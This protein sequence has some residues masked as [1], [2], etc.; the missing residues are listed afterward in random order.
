MTTLL[1]VFG[2]SFGLSI[3]LTPVARS[4]AIRC[5]LIDEPDGRRKIHPRGIP[6]A[7]GPVLL[8]SGGGAILIAL[9]VHNPLQSWLADQ[10]QNLLSLFLAAFV[11]CLLGIIDD[12]GHLRGR[13]KLVGQLLAITIVM[14]TGL[15]V[16]QI[17]LFDWDVELGLLAVP[18]TLFL[19]LGAI[20]SLNLIDG[21]DGLL[22]CV[23]LIISLAMAVMAI[24]GGLWATACVAVALAGALLGFLRFNFPPASIFLGDS[25]SMLIGLAIGSLAIR[26]SLKGPATIA[27]AAP[28]A[29]LAIPIFDTTAAIIRR[30]LTGRS[31]YTTDRGH[32]HHCLLRRGLSTGGV[33]LWISF[34][35]LLTVCGALVS[36]ALHNELLA[37]VTASVVVSILI[38]TRIF[39]YAEFL[40][41]KERLSSLATSFLRRRARGN[42]HEIQVRLQGTADWNELW[43]ALTTYASQLNLSLV[44]LNVNAPLLHEGYH[45]C[46]DRFEDEADDGN[47]WCAE[48]PLTLGGQPFGRLEIAGHPNG[49]PIWMQI[50]TMAKLLEDFEALGPSPSVATD[51]STQESKVCPVKPP[52]RPEL[53]L[54]G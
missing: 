37:I 50:A 4:L 17:R 46:W 38:I 13:H 42:A 9:T 52:S 26:S 23:G 53:S 2:L 10:S 24:L 29:V 41:V 47:R 31:I 34:F 32:L 25:G 8:L 33:V 7:G 14:S 5:R 44:R 12:Y 15:V 54:D 28:V 3:L 48:I 6:T 16:R 19:L 51:V 22:T 40:L 43:A 21:I 45:A 39:G 20:N 18:F 11:I 36:L 30:K 1:A 27:L 35:C 49:E